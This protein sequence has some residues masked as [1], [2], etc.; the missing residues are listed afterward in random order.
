M[1]C[2][3][4]KHC[5]QQGHD[6]LH[7]VGKRQIAQQRREKEQ[8]RKEG[9]EKSVRKLRG[10]PEAVIGPRLG[11]D[12]LHQCCHRHTTEN[13]L[14]VVSVVAGSHGP[15]PHCD[16]RI[17]RRVWTQTI[18]AVQTGHMGVP[19][20]TKPKMPKSHTRLCRHVVDGLAKQ[21]AW[22]SR[23][24][25][26]GYGRLCSPSCGEGPL[27]MPVLRHPGMPWV[28]FALVLRQPLEPF[29]RGRS[30]ASGALPPPTSV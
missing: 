7:E 25:G 4:W 9:E 1:E 22:P 21:R 30:K 6:L 19:V 3:P 5:C 11:E 2:L 23:T 24:L 15:S 18:R 27:A 16:A 26:E 17:A 29:A 20:V 10:L 28:F 12:A 14:R 13:T 8:K